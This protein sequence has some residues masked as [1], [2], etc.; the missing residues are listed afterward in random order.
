M[1]QLWEFLIRSNF[2]LMA[3]YSKCKLRCWAS[4]D[5]LGN[6][7]KVQW[8]GPSWHWTQIIYDTFKFRK[9]QFWNHCNSDQ[10]FSK[11]INSCVIFTK[12]VTVDYVKQGVYCAL[13]LFQGQIFT[14]PNWRLL[15]DQM[16]LILN[17]RQA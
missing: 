17:M 15:W 3:V 4:Q 8:C 14:L 16:C 6:N 12:Y 7:F 5:W 9:H 13:R 1:F 10:I 11:K 2:F